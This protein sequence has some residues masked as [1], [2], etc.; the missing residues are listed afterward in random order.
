MNKISG[1]KKQASKAPQTSA[2]PETWLETGTILDL[3]STADVQEG[4]HA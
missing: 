4:R 1:P 3:R 2:T